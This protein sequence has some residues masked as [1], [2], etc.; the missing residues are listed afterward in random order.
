[1]RAELPAPRRAPRWP[2]SRSS[3]MAR[4]SSRAGPSPGW[5]RPR[6]VMADLA[7]RA[8]SF[9]LRH[10]RRHRQGRAAG[11]RRRPHPPRLRRLPGRGV[12]LAAPGRELHGDHAARRRHPEHRARHPRRLGRRAR[13]AR[14]PSAST[15]CS[16]SASRP[17]RA[18]AA[19]AWTGRPRSSSSRS[20]AELEPCASGRPGAD[21]PGRPRRPDRIP[22]PDRTGIVDF[23]LRRG[24]SPR[25]PDGKLAEFCDVFCEQG[26]F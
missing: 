2:S 11:L 16:P 8:R 10:D 4:W 25:S 18:R 22:G 14:P 7:P 5:G 24:R 9:H 13:R 17:S 26:V 20:M 6:E 21:L 12:R 15:P 23:L 19:T 3:P 1:M